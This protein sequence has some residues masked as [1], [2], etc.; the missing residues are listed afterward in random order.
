MGNT[1]TKL[2]DNF[3]TL[4]VEAEI[5]PLNRDVLRIRLYLYPEFT[6][7][8]RHHGTSEPYWVWV[9][10]S[11]TSEIYHHEYFH[12][13]SKRSCTIAMNSISQSRY[14]IQCLAR[15]MFERFLIGGWGAETV[16][17]CHFNISFRPDTESVIY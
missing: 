6:W 15:Y 14:P 12:S 16:T 5:A 2:L 4:S 7:N 11:D 1:L 13:Q 9:E 8:D 10:N 17:Q 3:P